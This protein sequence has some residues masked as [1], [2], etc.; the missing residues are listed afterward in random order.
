MTEFHLGDTIDEAALE[1]YSKLLREAYDN[2]ES[3]NATMDWNDVQAALDK[4]I[5]AFGADAEAFK[6][7]ADAGFDDE[8]LLSTPAD[9]SGEARSAAQ[10]IFAY[11]YP[12]S[13]DIEDVDQA[14]DTLLQTEVERGVKPSR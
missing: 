2:G 8:P 6:A 13:V 11:R 9:I 3:N 7:A 10:L 14:F 1:A 5:E 12:E 4:A